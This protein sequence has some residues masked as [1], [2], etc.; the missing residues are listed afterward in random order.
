MSRLKSP[1]ATAGNSQGWLSGLRPSKVEQ[2]QLPE[3]VRNTIRDQQDASEILIG[4]VQLGV[5]SLFGGLYLLAPKTFTL[6]AEF[7]PVPWV[8]GGYLA[9]TLMR[10]AVSLRR[11]TPQWML[12]VSVVVDMALLFVLIWSFHHQYMQPPS[13]YL[14]APTLLYVF[15][16]IHVK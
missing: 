13:F 5:V 4:W 8:L 11:R 1:P 12:Y 9:F 6:E 16:F 14:K 3:R 15:I 7:A 2:P 10:L